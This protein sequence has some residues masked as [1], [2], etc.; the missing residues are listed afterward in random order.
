MMNYEHLKEYENIYETCMIASE[1]DI[2]KKSPWELLSPIENPRYVL[3]RKKLSGRYQYKYSFACPAVIGRKR[4][5]LR[6]L[7]KN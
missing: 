4:N 7:P 2:V 1:N 6:C 3:I 5:M